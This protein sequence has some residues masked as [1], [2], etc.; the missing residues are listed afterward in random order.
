MTPEQKA[1]YVMSQAASAL[2]EAMGMH[3]CNMQRA[4]CGYSMAYDEGAFLS[5]IDKYGISHN[6]VHSYTHT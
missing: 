6:A 2:I 4:A 5:I 1:A 3:A